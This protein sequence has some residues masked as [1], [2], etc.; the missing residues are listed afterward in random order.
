[1][2]KSIIGL[3]WVLLTVLNAC[4]AV[5]KG[6][7]GTDAGT[8]L[9]Q[10]CWTHAYEEEASDGVKVYRPCDYMT[11]PPSRFRDSFSLLA[12]GECRYAVLAP[13]DAHGQAVGRWEYLEAEAQ[14]QIYDGSEVLIRTWTI[15]SLED[16]LLR[17]QE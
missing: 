9:L 15:I 12:N 7:D 8:N 11:F 10:G 1:M 4:P 17:I 3:G 2:S 16:N 5:D 6:G 14:V 13:N